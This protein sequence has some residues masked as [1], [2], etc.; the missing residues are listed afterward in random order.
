MTFINKIGIL[1]KI[2]KVINVIKENN[3][4]DKTEIIL[5]NV[6]QQDCQDLEDEINELKKK[7]ENLF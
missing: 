1:Q 3:E 6:I 2:S 7:L 4:N 5:S